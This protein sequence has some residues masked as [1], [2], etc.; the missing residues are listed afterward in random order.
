[1]TSSGE[2]DRLNQNGQH[3]PVTVKQWLFTT[4]NQMLALCI[5]SG[6]LSLLTVT[7][8][9]TGIIHNIPYAWY[10]KL[11]FAL[12]ISSFSSVIILSTI[13]IACIHA[14]NRMYTP[15]ARDLAERFDMYAV[16]SYFMFALGTISYLLFLFHSLVL[17]HVITDDALMTGFI[18]M[19]LLGISVPLC[20]HLCKISQEKPEEY[21]K[22][23]KIE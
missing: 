7:P 11:F 10:E 4:T 18:S 6:F 12:S 23:E 19:F 21:E 15:S 2:Y 17:Y 22:T 1:M 8:F 9:M 13:I 5:A 16:I 14:A 20:I 3:I